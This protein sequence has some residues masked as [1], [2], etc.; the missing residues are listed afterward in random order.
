M[1]LVKAKGI[2]IDELYGDKT[3][4]KSEDSDGEDAE[5]DGDNSEDGGEEIDAG[6]EDEVPGA[7]D[8][9]S[10]VSEEPDETKGVEGDDKVKAEGDPCEMEDDTPGEIWIDL[11]VND[12]RFLLMDLW[13][14]FYRREYFSAC[15]FCCIIE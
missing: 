7:G 14:I 13:K 12:L 10:G 2:A 15:S 11:C 6:G 4:H 1:A 3:N 5:E 9:A 8:K